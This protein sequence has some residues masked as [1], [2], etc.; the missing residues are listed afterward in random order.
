MK[1]LRILQMTKCLVTGG[2]GFIG[3]HLAE[4][5]LK[6]GESV[7]VLDDLST[8]KKENIEFL[9]KIPGK[10]SFIQASVLDA[11]LVRNALEG[12]DVIFHQAALGSVPK[13]LIDPFAYNEVNATGTLKL[14]I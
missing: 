5:L 6:R 7:V 3:S 8:G 1:T 2:A 11:P 13:S 9:K 10:F 4:F 12:I 14:L